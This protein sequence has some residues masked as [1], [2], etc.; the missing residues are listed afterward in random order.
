[1]QPPD[2]DRARRGDPS[3]VV[4]LTATV[5]LALPWAAL[6]VG[7]YGLVLL[8]ASDRDGWWWLAAGAALLVIDIVIDLIWAAPA[9]LGTDEPALNARASQLIGRLAVVD[10]PLI[11]GR[12]RVA[13]GDGAWPAEG[14]DAARGERVRIV[15]VSGSSL[16]VERAEATAP[17]ADKSNLSEN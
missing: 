8:H 13:I 14:P 12:G 17:A 16:I 7:A 1:V 3:A 2:G 9:M 11:G 15:A 6:G 4:W 5:S 10:E